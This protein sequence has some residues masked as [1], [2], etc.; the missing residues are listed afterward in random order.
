MTSKTRYPCPCCGFYTLTEEPPGTFD[1]CP[2]CLWEDD[3]VQFEHPTLAG[4]ANRESLEEAR[5]NY[6]AFGAVAE[7]YIGRVRPPRTD[8]LP[9][10]IH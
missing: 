2:V 3:N 7:Q 1:I 4:G 5:A 9:P 8:E 6:K 10:L